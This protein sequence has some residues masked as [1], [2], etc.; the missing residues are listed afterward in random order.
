MMKNIKS[1]LNVLFLALLLAMVLPMAQVVMLPSQALAQDKDTKAATPDKPAKNSANSVVVFVDHEGEDSVGAK[2]SFML[3][4]TFNSSSL[5]NLSES[6]EPK[7]WVLLS[8]AP[9][10]SSRPGVG[11]V[12][13]VVWVFSQGEGTLRLYLAREVGTVTADE[14]PGLVAKLSERTYGIAQKYNYLFQK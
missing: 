8:T 7:L 1:R 4:E 12:Y 10:F 5:F 11:S 9:E 13:S 14:V 3:K 6:K 2:V